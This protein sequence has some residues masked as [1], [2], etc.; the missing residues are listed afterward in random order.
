MNRTAINTAIFQRL[1]G[2][3][4]LVN[5]LGG[6]ALYFQN[7]PDNRALPYVIW[8]I[9]SRQDE[10]ETRNRTQNI[11]AYIRAYASTPIQAAQIDENI[12]ALMHDNP[13]TITGV[14]SNFWCMRED[15]FDLVETDQSTR[16]IYSAG[17]QYRLLIDI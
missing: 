8:D 6:T 11:L 4:A 17:A 12:D 7:A 14:T 15:S 13:L 1:A 9:A 16:R 3:T 10:N 5:S 2:G